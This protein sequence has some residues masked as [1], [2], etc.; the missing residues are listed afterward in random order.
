M[1]V[2]SEAS[3]SMKSVA[4]LEAALGPLLSSLG[5]TVRSALPEA[6]PFPLPVFLTLFYPN[7]GLWHWAARGRGWLAGLSEGQVIA[8]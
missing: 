5:E 6:F 3:V 7:P 4:V 8:V 1:Q 2:V